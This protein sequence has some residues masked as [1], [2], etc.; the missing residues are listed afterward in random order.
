M[1]TFT[2]RRFLFALTIGL[3]SASVL[4]LAACQSIQPKPFTAG[5]TITVPQGCSQLLLRDVQGDC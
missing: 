5:R 3:S 4:N 2:R 1:S